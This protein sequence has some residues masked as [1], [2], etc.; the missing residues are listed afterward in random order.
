MSVDA[1]PV[2]SQSQKPGDWLPSDILCRKKRLTSSLVIGT[3]QS[4]GL[5][6]RHQ[7][8]NEREKIE[9]K[10][11]H[12]TG[13]ARNQSDQYHGDTIHQRHT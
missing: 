4:Y 13:F 10:I 6:K 11:K 3:F 8:R 9:E 5:Y 2:I 7:L 1:A 12:S